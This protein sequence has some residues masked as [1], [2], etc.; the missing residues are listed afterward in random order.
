M[1]FLGWGVGLFAIVALAPAPAAAHRERGRHGRAR[2]AARGPAADRPFIHPVAPV[3][4]GTPWLAIHVPIIVV[5]YSVLA[6][7]T[8]SRTS[9]VGVEIFAPAGAT[10]SARWSELLY[11][12]IHVGI[13]PAH[14][15]HPDR[16]DLGRLLVG[17]LL[18]L[19]PEGG[20]VAG[21][22]PRLHG[23]PARPLRRAD[24]Q[25]RRRRRSIA[26]FWT[27][28]MTYLGV[29]FVLASG[30][31]AYGF[32]TRAA[33]VDGDRRRRRDRVRRPRMAGRKGRESAERPHHPPGRGRLSR[34]TC[35]RRA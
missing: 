14:R 13:D 12:Y 18:G 21:R 24:P 28:L 8:G 25:L 11:W 31:H 20:L 1:L 19:G 15:G 10:S 16:L 22:V 27:I 5:S 9:S 26:A 30:L 32:G 7:A 35:P 6:M 34:R 17:P 3:L 33:P 23:D 29:N 2:D 4:S